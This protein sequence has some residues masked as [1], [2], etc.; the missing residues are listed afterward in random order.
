VV[1][2]PARASRGKRVPASQAYKPQNIE[3]GISNIEV[4]VIYFCGSLFC[5]SIFNLFL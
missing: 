5:C 2:L 3:Q 1:Y 4:M